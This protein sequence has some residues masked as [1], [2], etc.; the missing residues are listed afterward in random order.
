[1]VC[2]NECDYARMSAI[3]KNYS[4]FSRKIENEKMHGSKTASLMTEREQ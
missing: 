2:R 3:V 4:H 1:M